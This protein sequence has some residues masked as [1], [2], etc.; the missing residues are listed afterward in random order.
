MENKWHVKAAPNAAR[1]F[2]RHRVLHRHNVD[3]QHV[4]R[5]AA[6]VALLLNVNVGL[7]G[8]D[9]VV[10]EALRAFKLVTVFTC[11]RLEAQLRPERKG[12]TAV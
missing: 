12:E 11:D 2:K 1:V 9:V 4:A 3:R 8:V 6:A 10:A 5:V 7:L